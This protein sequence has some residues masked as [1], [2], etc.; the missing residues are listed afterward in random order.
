MTHMEYA[1]ATA[2]A[3][4]GR[5]M[6]AL[7]DSG[8]LDNTLVVLTADHGS[9]AAAEGHFHGDFEPEQRLRLLQLVLRR[10]RAT[11]PPTCDP[12]DALLRSST[13]R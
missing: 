12:Q 5:I 11:T 8:E 10:R 7:E 2:D 3:Q 1:T 9:V 13:A 6:Q 4:V